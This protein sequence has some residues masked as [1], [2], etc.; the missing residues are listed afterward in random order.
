M[1]TKKA[2]SFQRVWEFDQL[3]R[4]ECGSLLCGV[5]EA[6]RGPL[7][8]PVVAAAVIFPETVEPGDFFDSKQLSKNAREKAYAVALEQAVDIGVGIVDHH[9]IDQYNIL[10]ATL[11]AMQQAVNELKHSPNIVIVDGA[12]IPELQYHQRKINHGDSLSQSIGAASIIAK[13]TRDRLMQKY[14]EWYPEYGFVRHMGYGTKE[15]MLA[16]SKYGPSPIHRVSFAPIKGMVVMH[17]NSPSKMV[18]V[19]KDWGQIGE[20]FAV[21]YLENLGYR[22]IERN[23]RVR[24]GEVDAIMQDGESLVFVE[25]R[26]RH[27][28]FA[29]LSFQ[30]TAESIGKNKRRRLRMLAQW[31]E[32]HHVSV[33]IK[34][35]RVDVV[36]VHLP[37]NQGEPQLVHYPG[38][39]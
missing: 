8:G 20:N 30:L 29:A 37:T 4:Q 1:N 36:L 11:L 31:Y 25:V 32:Q 10:K 22:C 3:L 19:R 26:S 34:N 17:G 35:M 21:H 38:V 14:D 5:D 33:D 24:L 6:G 2:E 13:V 12:A 23:W 15:H 9:F 16:L 27:S 7:A 39:L 18:D 28:E